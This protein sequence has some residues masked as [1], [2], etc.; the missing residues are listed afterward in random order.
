MLEK[1]LNVEQ[2]ST[3]YKEDRLSALRKSA[4]LTM[5]ELGSVKSPIIDNRLA[6]V[7]S[8][9]SAI[10]VADTDKAAALLKGEHS[11]TRDT[12]RAM[13]SD[14]EHA[15]SFTPKAALESANDHANYTSYPKEVP[16]R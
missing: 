6:F 14:R 5:S 16:L 8:G 2:Q 7:V 1:T 3:L 9:T 4:D 15:N 13:V 12:H 10:A 11:I